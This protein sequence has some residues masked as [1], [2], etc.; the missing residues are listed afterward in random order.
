MDNFYPFFRTF[1]LNILLSSFKIDSAK[2]M[3]L[4]KN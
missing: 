2:Y 4:K 1:K 3:D